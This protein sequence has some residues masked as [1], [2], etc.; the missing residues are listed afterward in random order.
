[1]FVQ[2][3]GVKVLALALAE[4]IVLSLPLAA[5]ATDLTGQGRPIDRGDAASCAQSATTFDRVPMIKINHKEA[6]FL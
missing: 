1:M 4:A 5:Q 3:R 6:C 2:F